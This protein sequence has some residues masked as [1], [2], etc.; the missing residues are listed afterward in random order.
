MNFLSVCSGIEAASVAFAPLGWQA[1][2]FAEIEPFP[3]ALL[4]HHY[5]DVPNLGDLTQWR[6]WPAALLLRVD[7]LVGGTPCQAFSLA[8]LRESLDDARGNLTL[9][10]CELYDHLTTLRRTAGLPTPVCLWEN[11][12]GVLS[13]HDN[14]FGCFLAGLAGESLPLVPA[15]PA[16]K[17]GRPHKWADAGAVLG[18]ARAVA[19]R[20]LDAQYFG[21]AQRR[22]RV[23]ALASADPSF[24]PLAVLFELEGLRRDTPPRREPGQSTAPTLS[25][26]TKGGGGLGTDAE[27]DGAVIAVSAASETGAGVWTDDGLAR[28]RC[29]SAPTQP[30]N[31]VAYGGNNQSGPID[32]ATTRNA[33]A[34]ATGRLDFE[35]E[36]FL[37]HPAEVSGTLQAN[38]KAAGSATQQDAEN[39]FLV[40]VAFKASH[41]TRSKDGAPDSITPPLCADAAQGDQD[42][43]VLAPTAV[44]FAEN[45]RSELRLEGG[46][47]QICGSLSTGGGK[48]GQGTPTVAIAYAIQERAV[49]ENP[50]AG[51]GG[52]GVS[53]DNVAYTLEA[54]TK[55][56]AVAF[57]SQSWRVRRLTPEECELLQG[58]PI[59]Y[60]LL[61]APARKST[62]K[63]RQ[64][65][66]LAET[67]AYLVAL[68]FPNTE[69]AALA[70]SP[71]GPRYKAIGN[72]WPVPVVRWIARRIQQ[73][74][75]LVP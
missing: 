16:P 54:R 44:A 29:T 15:G 41:F 70:H 51:P 63:L 45:S 3:C 24:D 57:Q 21:L 12:P 59:G 62:A 66:D 18:P 31:I 73:N 60:T 14:A 33:S 38:G 26:R 64:P 58:F 61:P 32:I 46:D 11:V 55:P 65:A 7:I 22:R 40:P 10:F 28:V 2:A 9:T 69:A 47:G 37:V 56:Q 34:S 35:T 30:Q 42:T 8:G 19:W 23:F 50:A 74:R 53:S 6:T 48:A 4:A 20:T 27:C 39:G 49:C 13:T 17:P 52:M 36:T 1:V 25:A 72:S 68:G 71:D 5:P 43:L 67:V 75:S